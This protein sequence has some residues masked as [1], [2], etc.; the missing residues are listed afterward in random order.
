[1]NTFS[2]RAKCYL[3]ALALIA[4]GTANVHG[5]CNPATCLGTYATVNTYDENVVATNTV[6]ILLPNSNVTIEDFKL[7]MIA[8]HAAQTG[9]VVNFDTVQNQTESRAIKQ[10]DALFGSD[11]SFILT[12]TRT[13][14]PDPVNGTNWNTNSN[15]PNRISGANYLGNGGGSNVIAIFS[16]PLELFGI[17]ALDRG[18]AR[19]GTFRVDYQDGTFFDFA[20]PTG[21]P[22]SPINLADGSKLITHRAPVGKK[23]TGWRW[24]G[25]FIR[26]DDFGFIVADFQPGDADG[27]LDVDLDDFELIRGNLGKVGTGLAG[28]V[29]ANGI[30]DLND[31]KLWKQ[32]YPTAAP[33]EALAGTVSVPEPTSLLLGLMGAVAYLGGRRRQR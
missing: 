28:D 20:T 31:F 17:T 11:L 8:A 29:R 6:S 23:I 2:M 19:P 10:F 15:E 14:N 12:T 21:V 32:Y 27:D 4:V 7:E 9:G 18:G 25:N 24:T 5:Q 22:G 13:D 26:W 3:A 1:M 30:V 16:Q 33:L